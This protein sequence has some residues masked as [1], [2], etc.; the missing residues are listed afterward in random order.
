MTELTELHKTVVTLPSDTEIRTERIFDVS[1]EV[2]FECWV[3]PEVL[4]EWMGPDRLEMT[5]EEYDV[6]PGGKYRYVHRD[7]DSGSEYVFFGEFLEI[8][9]PSKL[10]QTFNFIMEPQPP[11][12]IDRLEL[13]PTEDGR[14]RMVTLTTFEAKEYRD[15]MIQGGMEKGMNEGFARLDKILAKRG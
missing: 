5:V 6:R 1:P 4:A 12:S 10:V 15:G 2:V 7:P 3:D 11:P 13:I 14:T 9:A 8:E